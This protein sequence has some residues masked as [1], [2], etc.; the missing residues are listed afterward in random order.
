MC[1]LL[2]SHFAGK[3]PRKDSPFEYTAEKCM[4]GFFTVLFAI[5]LFLLAHPY[6]LVW[7]GSRRVKI[8]RFGSFG[9]DPASSQPPMRFGSDGSEQNGAD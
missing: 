2:C 4:S 9:P 7:F 5:R 1:I 3:D 6:G 8:L